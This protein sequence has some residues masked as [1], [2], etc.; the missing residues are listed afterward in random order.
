MI[1]RLTGKIVARAP[2]TVVLDVSGVG[3]RLQI[4]LSTYYA[5]AR[6]DGETTTLHVHTHVREDALSLFGFATRNEQQAFE[7]L[8]TVS[9][10]GPRVALAVLSGI[11]A[12]DLESAVRG[13]DRALLERIPG[14]GRKTAERILL[15]LR[16]RYQRLDRKGRRAGT[17]APAGRQPGR[18]DPGDVRR[19][20][21]SALIHLGYSLEAAGR[22]VD[23]A[24]EEAGPQGALE[25]VL[26]SALRRL[27]R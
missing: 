5:L 3:Y 16:D 22:A 19:D 9:G 11:G 1:G 23:A 12:E 20:A 8:I 26:R 2:D 24:L 4:P 14:I 7:G 17:A 6:S 10:V 13:G 18:E 15:D 27:T 21:E 25:S